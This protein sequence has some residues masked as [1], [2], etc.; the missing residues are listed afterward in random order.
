MKRPGEVATV[1]L[2][3][4]WPARIEVAGRVYRTREVIDVW[5]LEGG[6]WTGEATR[7][8]YFRLLAR[9]GTTLEVYR[10]ETD[11][12]LTRILD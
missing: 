9:C 7:R 4:G 8:V 1:D 6:W 5:V 11:W 2:D 3:G 10:C 12:R